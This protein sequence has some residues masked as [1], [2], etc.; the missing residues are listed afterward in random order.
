MS[1]V[2]STTA[3]P[4]ARSV[5]GPAPRP[6]GP[7]AARRPSVRAAWYWERRKAPNRWYW[8]LTVV[9]CSL[10]A[11]IGYMQYRDYQDAF[12]AQEATWEVVW[13]QSTLMLSMLFLPLAVAAFTAQAASGE[14]AGRNWQR[15]AA[16]RLEGVMVVGKLLHALQA[17]LFTAL[18]LVGEITATGLLLGFDA[19]DLA[20]Y[21]P[22]VVPVTLAVWAI[23]VLVMWLGVVLESFAAMMTTVFLIT[24]TG[25]ALSLAAPA[26]AAIDPM[27]LLTLACSSYS[28]RDTASPGSV[29]TAS[30]VCLA[31]VGILAL[32]L[33][34]GV[35]RRS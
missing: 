22:R 8:P 19:A 26:L 29:L 10:G 24:V 14:H 27:G 17:A 2:T 5:A 9:L 1:A 21:L 23:E 31:W 18:I 7:A 13:A 20:R 16:N 11:L 28:P 12:E 4:T 34:A 35:R 25:L 15:M 30:V 3:Y 32:A 33:R 6:G